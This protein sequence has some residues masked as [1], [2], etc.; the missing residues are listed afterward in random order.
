MRALV[1]GSTGF[2]GAA[3][4]RALTARGDAVVAFHRASSL[5]R[6]LDGLPVEHAIGDLTR[7]ETLVEALQGVDVLFHTAAHMGGGQAGRQYAVTVEGTRALMNAALEAGVQR[8]VHTSSVA[9]LGVPEELPAGGEPSLLNEHH[10]WNFRPD[11]W[12]YG[13]AKY[14]AEMEVQ[15]AV[16]AGLDAVIVNPT[17]VYGA[18]DVYRQSSSL[19]MQAARR[20]IPA[21]VDG[22][23][24]VVHIDDVAAGHLAA[25]ER[26]G[27]GRRYILGG[28][29]MTI[30]ALVRL[31]AEVTG[32]PPPGVILPVGLVRRLAGPLE[33]LRDYIRLGALST[34][35]RLA[36]RYFYYDL[37]RADVELGHRPQHSAREA[38]AEAYAW[39]TQAAP[40]PETP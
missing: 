23:V 1:T 31:A 19:V 27:R 2:I 25:L 5:L 6:L 10:T 13:Y 9:A 24:N 12:P 18:G 28:E 4:C 14:L 38:L 15:R 17:V 32:T 8:V 30:A 29:N 36:G 22:G 21:L 16:A 40:Q 39:F 33:R 35:L 11:H 3:L 37:S 7:P 34:E 20:K 26:G